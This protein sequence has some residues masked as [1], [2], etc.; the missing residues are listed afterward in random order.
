MTTDRE[1]ANS[2]SKWCNLQY[3]NTYYVCL[4]AHNEPVFHIDIFNVHF[5][6]LKSMVIFSSSAI[7]QQNVFY[8]L[9][10]KTHK[11]KILIEQ[12]FEKKKLSNFYRTLNQ[13][14]DMFFK[15][16]IANCQF[17][18]WSMKPVADRSNAIQMVKWWWWVKFY[19]YVWLNSNLAAISHFLCCY[20]D[21]K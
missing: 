10:M 16:I 13:F 6:R 18:S 2:A 7:T 11:W 17:Q 15:H 19:I 20:H 21:I 5:N 8:K 12:W 3:A 9:E 14:S 4:W 1:W